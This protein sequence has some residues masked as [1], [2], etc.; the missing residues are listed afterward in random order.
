MTIEFYKKNKLLLFLIFSLILTTIIELDGKDF[1]EV[2][3]FFFIKDYF[4]SLIIIFSIPVLNNYFKKLYDQEKI[5]LTIVIVVNILLIFLINYF[6]IKT[7]E[8]L[9]YRERGIEYNYSI[10][11]IIFSVFQYNFSIVG[12]FIIYYVSYLIDSLITQKKTKKNRFIVYYQDKIFPIKT[13]N[14]CGFYSI[15]N[16]TY[17]FTNRGER[18]KTNSTLKEINEKL[19]SNDFF[20][21]NRQTILSKESVKSISPHMNRKLRVQTSIDFETDLIVSKSKAPEFLKWMES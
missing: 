17:L 9:I 6:S 15:N 21:I 4:V 1:R 16:V 7:N 18:Y 11:E 12:G 20:Q 14:V 3:G 10:V 8:I 5:T 2:S 13:T 19:H